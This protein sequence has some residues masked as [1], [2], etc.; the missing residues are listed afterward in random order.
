MLR[1]FFHLIAVTIIVLSGSFAERHVSAAGCLDQTGC[2]DCCPACGYQ[3]DFDAECKDET[4]D[5]FDVESKVIC[6]PRVVFPWQRRDACGCMRATCS[7]CI[8]NGA[9]LRRVCV[10]KRDSKTCPKCKYDW[11]AKKRSCGYPSAIEA[12]PTAADGSGVAGA[13]TMS[14][15][16]GESTRLQEAPYEDFSRPSPRGYPMGF[17]ESTQFPQPLENDGLPDSGGLFAP[18]TGTPGLQ[19]ALTFPTPIRPN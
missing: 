14:A 4:I 12:M 1:P 11:E 15:V 8:H 19:E 18:S 5:G 3:C 17:E 2:V 13:S 7:K 6:I 16:G 10:L 9:R